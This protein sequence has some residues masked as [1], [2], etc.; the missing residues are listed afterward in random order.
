MPEN[1]AVESTRIRNIF[2]CDQSAIRVMGECRGEQGTEADE[3]GSQEAQAEKESGRETR[4]RQGSGAE[5]L[6][7]PE[8]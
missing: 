8:G 1:F 2:A 4:G 3:P 7:T 5:I 6:K